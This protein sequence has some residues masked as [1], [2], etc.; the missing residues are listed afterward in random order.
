M[1]PEIVP[2][3]YYLSYIKSI[4]P[5]TQDIAS[6][7]EFPDW[8]HDDIVKRAVSLYARSRSVTEPEREP[9]KA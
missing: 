3:T 8:Y 7:S 1:A 2:V 6:V 5:L 4:V 9:E